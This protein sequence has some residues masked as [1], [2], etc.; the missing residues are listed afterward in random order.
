[1]CD[2]NFQKKT[3]SYISIVD[4]TPAHRDVNSTMLLSTDFLRRKGKVGISGLKDCKWFVHVM[5]N[6]LAIDFI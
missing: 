3:C 2:P 1:M 6:V 4:S 5:L